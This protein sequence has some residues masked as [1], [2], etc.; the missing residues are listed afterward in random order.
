MLT[1]ICT[2]QCLYKIGYIRLM[3]STFMYFN[4]DFSFYSACKAPFD[5]SM[6]SHVAERKLQPVHNAVGLT[7]RLP[8]RVNLGQAL[9]Q[10][11]TRKNTAAESAQLAKQVASVAACTSGLSCSI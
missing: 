9:R 10:G 11:T 2:V 4:I 8:K 5:P 1:S 7:L 6:V 3:W